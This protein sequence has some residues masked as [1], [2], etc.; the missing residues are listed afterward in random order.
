VQLPISG[1]S[2]KTN[3]SLRNDTIP[4]PASPARVRVEIFDPFIKDEC[5]I[6]DYLGFVSE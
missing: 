1:R 3:G 6:F 2:R 4:D 5:L